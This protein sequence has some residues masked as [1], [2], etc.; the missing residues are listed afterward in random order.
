MKKTEQKKLI[1]YRKFKGYTQADIA[2]ALGIELRTY[3]NKEQGVSQFKINE[4][5]LIA[6]LLQMDIGDIFLPPNFMKHEVL[7]SSQCDC[8]TRKE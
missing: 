6:R 2:K 7:D 8:V 3:I 4:M 5:F 1:A